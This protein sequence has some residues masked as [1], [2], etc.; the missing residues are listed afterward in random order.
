MTTPLTDE[1]VATDAKQWLEENYDPDISVAEW[2]SRLA[3]SGWAAPTWAPDS[4]GKGLTNAQAAAAYRVFREAMVP[5]P[6]GGLSFMLAAPTIIAHGTEEQKQ[7][8]VRAILTGEEAWCQLF[9]EPGAGSDLASLQTRAVRDGD[10]WIVNGQKVWTSGAVG[11]DMGM[12][13]ARTNP[14]APKHKGI[15]YFALEM[16][17]PGVDVRP[18]KQITGQAHFS[19]VFFTDARVHN[20]ANIGGLNEG[21]GVALTTLANERVGLGGGGAGSFGTSAPGGRAQAKAR[22][23]GLGEF[24]EKQRKA[25]SMFSLAGQGG[26]GRGRGRGATAMVDLAKSMGRD[27]DAIIR[28]DIASLYTL[29]KLSEWNALRA[30]AAVAAGS[31]PGPEASIGK[32]MISRITRASRDLGMAIVGAGGM[33]TGQDA[34]LSGMMVLQFL[35]SPAPSIY[36][37]TDE[38]QKN[39][40]G[41]RVL[42]LPKEPDVSKDVPFKELKVGTQR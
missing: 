15:T 24:I 40:V 38:V 3:D 10:E 22:E 39:I 25:P 32:L 17:Q 23:Q 7:R 5:G 11:S 6:P 13:I 36:G 35:G 8:Y 18:L 14:D 9:S 12:L 37:G 33:I 41:E 19:E 34:P 28:Q 31:R 42:G 30:K 4:F 29:N 21:W 26:G 27:K 16:D 20:D 1:Q 2:L